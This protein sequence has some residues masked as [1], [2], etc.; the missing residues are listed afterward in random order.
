MSTDLSPVLAA[1]ARWLNRSYPSSG[2]AF[3]R[4]LAETQA[5]QAVT[6]AARLRYSTE[7]DATLVALA[8]PG[9]SARLDRLAGVET[10]SDD[11]YA[12]R[13][14][15]DE[16]LASWACCLLADPDLATEAV[17][18]TEHGTGMPAEFR[19]L[20]DPGTRERAA[21]PLLRHPDLLH[22]V[23]ELH[24]EQLLGLLGVEGAAAA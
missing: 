18:A 2:G 9:G 13:T 5:Q 4:V 21:T 24:R 11:E 17:A 19:R 12:W 1:T 23:A 8:G 20:T 10:L 22:P 16:V 15:V 7:M 6:V 3:D 14:W